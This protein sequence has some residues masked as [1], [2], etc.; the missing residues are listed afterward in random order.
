METGEIGEEEGH[1]TGTDL[2]GIAN[3]DGIGS[4][5]LGGLT[6]HLLA[7]SANLSDLAALFPGKINI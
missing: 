3:R 2:D 6:V 7:V 5:R 4:D 1:G